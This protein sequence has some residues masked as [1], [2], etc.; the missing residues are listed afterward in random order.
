MALL[1]GQVVVQW[2]AVEAALAWHEPPANP[3]AVEHLGARGRDFDVADRAAEMAA[4]RDVPTAQV[5]LSWLLHRPGVTTPIVG[6][7]SV[8]HVVGALDR[9]KVSRT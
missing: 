5:A 2:L 6:A 7:T 9:R 4:E 8:E 1:D 3:E